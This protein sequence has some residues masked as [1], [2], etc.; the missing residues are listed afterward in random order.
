MVQ[1]RDI[2]TEEKRY[3]VDLMASERDVDGLIEALRS[4]DSTVR[5]SAALGLGRLG[6]WRA[7]DPLIGALADPVQGVREGA[8][9]ALV[10]IGTPAVEPLTDLLLHPEVSER[11]ELPRKVSREGLTQFDLLAG[12]EGIPPEKRSLRHMGG[13]TQHDILGGPED[14]RRA[15]GRRALEEEEEG[16]TQHDLL[17]GPEGIPPEKRAL[18]HRVLAQHDLLAGPRGV[19]EHEALF[20]EVGAAGVRAEAPPPGMVWDA[21]TRRGL[22]RAYAAAILGEIADP[23]AE[24]PLT[25][26]LSDSD[27]VVR[28]AAEDAIV[29]FREKRGEVTPVPPASR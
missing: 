19:K 29:R 10:M 6:E 5:R 26:S 21:G 27:P 15:R 1:R 20:P 4:G 14:I 25:R 22:R 9:N 13:L 8:A 11:Y 17:A 7:V 2:S 18:Q 16:I 28:R 12:P 3:D 23:R 24:E